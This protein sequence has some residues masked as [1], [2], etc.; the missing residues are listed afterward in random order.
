MPKNKRGYLDSSEIGAIQS[1]VQLI[2]KGRGLVRA[3]VRNQT[4]AYHEQPDYNLATQLT[5]HTVY[6]I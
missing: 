6:G 4:A 2:D 1:L 5:A 3:R